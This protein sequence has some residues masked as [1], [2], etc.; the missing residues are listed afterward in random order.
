MK[1]KISAALAAMLAVCAFSGC[2]GKGGAGKRVTFLYTGSG[3]IGT[4]ISLLIDTYNSTQGKTD[5]VSIRAASV[6][7]G[8]YDTRMSTSVYSDT[9]DLYAT[10]DEYY[11][12][13]AANFENLSDY[14]GISDITS[15]IYD[16]QLGR[17][18]YNPEKNTSNAEDSLYALPLVNSITVM[19]YNKTLL[20]KA[21]VICIGV[22]EKDL[23]AFNAGTLAD[24]YGRTKSDYGITVDVPAK[25]FYR[26]NAF[27]AKKNVT[28]GSGWT[29]PA[30]NEVMIFNDKIAMSWDESEDVAML[31]TKSKNAASPTDYG[32]HTEWWFGYGWSVG[33]DC[34]E[35][36][37]DGDWKYTLPDSTAN[38]IVAE[39]KTY[40]GEYT[41][42]TYQ[43][44]ETLEFLDKL[45]V[46]KGETVMANDDNTFSVNGKVISVRESLAAAVSGGTLTELPSTAEA[47]SRFAMLAGVGGLN[48]CPRPENIS[49]AITFFNSG[50]LAFCV[51]EMRY[52]PD[53]E[54]AMSQRNNEWGVCKLPVY[55]TYDENGNVTALGKEAAHSL[56]YGIAINKLSGMKNEAYKVLS[57]MATEGQ[58]VLAENGYASSQ[59]A[60]E[61]LFIENCKYPNASVI[62][63]INADSRPG[64]WWYMPDRLWINIWADPLNGQV[65]N[66]KMTLADF[67]ANYTAATNAALALYKK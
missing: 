27:V 35:D 11:K 46:N 63:R 42:I 32:Y 12:K 25:G 2:V 5:N 59:K 48:V 1:K 8:G 40:T 37:G 39:G 24:A 54:K 29:L 15:G 3:E 49:N 58:K 33:G 31:M 9:Y 67:F 38:Y 66:G 41:G 23:A 13:Y 21:G 18:R 14:E 30:E 45:A 7:D 50:R 16:N 51:E 10:R 34:A 4:E 47:F 20:Q 22:E 28:D 19:Y 53:V 36:I 43:A 17:M 56:G 65:R 60:N 6:D 64:D 62:A 52:F 26:E 55:K 61:N 44:G 57:W